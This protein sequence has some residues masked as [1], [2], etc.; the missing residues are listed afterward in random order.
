MSRNNDRRFYLDSNLNPIRGE[1]R[2]PRP[3]FGR[4]SAMGGTG[5]GSPCPAALVAMMFSAVAVA[6][7]QVAVLEG[8]SWK[9]D[10]EPDGMA[11]DKGE[12]E[13]KDSLIFAEQRG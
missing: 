9:V 2:S 7:H 10:V 13:F 6:D 11:G 3:G 4:P 5:W 8:T 12:K 1:S